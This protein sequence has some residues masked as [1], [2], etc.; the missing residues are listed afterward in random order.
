M[1]SIRKN[2]ELMNKELNVKISKIYF[3]VLLVIK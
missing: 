1:D 3:F 2:I